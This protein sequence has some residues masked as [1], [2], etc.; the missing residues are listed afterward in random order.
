MSG[1]VTGLVRKSDKN[2][3]LTVLAIHAGHHHSSYH[4]GLVVCCRGTPGSEVA[5]WLPLVDEAELGRLG[6][7]IPNGNHVD[8]SPR[9][10]G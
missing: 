7:P 8:S 3:G 9:V 10:G 1:Y 4:C 2:H 5:Y 6:L